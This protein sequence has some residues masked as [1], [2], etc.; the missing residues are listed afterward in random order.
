MDIKYL[1]LWNQII[2]APEQWWGG[3]RLG[4]MTGFREYKFPSACQLDGV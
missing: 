2:R 4:G 1:L 3:V